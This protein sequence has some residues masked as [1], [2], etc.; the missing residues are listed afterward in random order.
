MQTYS[1]LYSFQGLWAGYFTQGG[2]LQH[3]TV[4]IAFQGARIL[5]EGRDKTGIFAIAGQRTTT[6]QA[7]FIKQYHGKHSVSCDGN[8]TPDEKSMHGKY[9]SGDAVGCFIMTLQG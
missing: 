7:H 4:N 9:K 2:K 5:G 6:G 3:F 1:I 8:F